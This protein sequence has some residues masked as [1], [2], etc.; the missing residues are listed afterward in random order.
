VR[1]AFDFSELRWSVYCQGRRKKNFSQNYLTAIVEEMQNGFFL[2]RSS[3]IG[4]R[5][6]RVDYYWYMEMGKSN[7]T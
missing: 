6:F 3:S 1:S 2:A 4:L 5:G 7:K